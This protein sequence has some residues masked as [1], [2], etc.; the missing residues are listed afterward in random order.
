MVQLRVRVQ[1]YQDRYFRFQFQYGTIKRAYVL[2]HSTVSIAFQF[3]YG[4]IKRKQVKMKEEEISEFQFQYGTIKRSL[5]GIGFQDLIT[6]QFQYGTIKRQIYKAI[7]KILSSFN[8]NMVQ[9][10]EN[11]EKA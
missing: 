3:Q 8:S 9:L 7:T 6:F 4:T 5:D 1:S 2:T 11:T 10:R